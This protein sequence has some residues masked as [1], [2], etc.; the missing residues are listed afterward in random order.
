M[1]TTLLI[2]IALHILSVISWMA[3]LLYLIRLCIYHRQSLA[4]N[5]AA[6]P[7]LT[8]QFELMERRVWRAILSPA[9]GFTLIT[10]I[11]LL[12]E[13]GAFREGWM[14]TKLLLV[15]LMLA[16]HWGAKS[17]M[18]A[19]KNK[20]LVL[21]DMKLRLFNEAPTVLMIG[22]VF[23]VVMKS[24]LIPMGVM[25]LSALVMTVVIGIM[26]QKT[27]GKK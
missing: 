10:G 18:M 16:V 6:T 24:I 8:A 27:A 13:T 3:G 14:H 12:I 21:T 5:D 11:W 9:M 2:F 26:G 15:V 17:I 1:T 22:I 7:I 20:R 25:V 19:L 4:A 23:L